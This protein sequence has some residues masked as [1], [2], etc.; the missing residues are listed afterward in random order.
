MACVWKLPEEKSRYWIARF[1][2]STG[3]RVNRSTK[4][5]DRRKAQKIAE[6]WEQAARLARN[7]ELVQASSIRLLDDLMKKTLGVGLKVETITSH[8]DKWIQGRADRNRADSTTKRYKSVTDSFLE[9]LGDE[10]STASIASL[11]AEEIEAWRSAELKDGKGETTA[12]FGV[13]VIRGALEEAR[14]KGLVLSNIAEAVETGESI[15]EGREPFTDDEIRRLLKKAD[16]EWTGMI[17]FGAHLG[18]RIA[19]AASLTWEQIDMEKCTLSIVP[20]KTKRTAPKKRELALHSELVRHLRTVQRGIGA[21]P[22][23]PSLYGRRPGSHAGLSN[24]FSRL[25]SKAGIVASFGAKKT[26][27]GRQLRMKGFHALRHSFISRL[28]NADI[29]G[30]VRKVLAGHASEATHK[31]Y[32]HL[33]LDTQIRAIAAVGAFAK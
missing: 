16:T 10:R 8:F 4:Q 12:D 29:S 27:K 31:K 9:F 3:R 19:D 32:V 30:D 23:F 13:K 28:A 18:L 21:A 25:M 1:S 6:T 15:Q 7:H 33:A 24:E 11:T 2:D 14:R 20:G 26:G 22:L 17:L 5:T